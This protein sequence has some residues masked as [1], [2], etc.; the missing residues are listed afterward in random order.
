MSV[1]HFSWFALQV[2]SRHES[3]VAGFLEAKGYELF[4]PLV[5]SRKRWSDRIKEIESPLFPGYVFCRFNV[6]E[7]LPILKTPGVIQIVGYN[8]TPVPV[9]E[10]EISGIQA[11]I[12]SGLPS[13]PWPFLTVG[14]NV[15]IEVGPLRGYQ[16]LLVD[17][18]G[19]HRLV[20]SISLL[21]R[22]VAVEIDSASV[23]SVH[24]SD[25]P[26]VQR[27]DTRFRPVRLAV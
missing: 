15:Q 4:L 10:V 21:H 22:S 6:L 16:G 26:A 1:E 14:Q 8:R 19:K 11:L 20:L 2:R 24:A 23:S 18:K 12:A 3:G 9:E 17:F 7:R 25:G 27:V 5:T 13:Q